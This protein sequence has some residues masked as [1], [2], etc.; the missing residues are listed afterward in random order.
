MRVLFATAACHPCPSREQCT[1]SLRYGRQLTIRPR[2]AP[3]DPCRSGHRPVADAVRGPLWR[4]RRHSPGRIHQA[5][6]TTGARRT[7]YIGLAKTRLGHVLPP[8][9]SA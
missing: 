4:R 8:P 9:P 6:A 7:R 5:V 1:N 3:A 2:R